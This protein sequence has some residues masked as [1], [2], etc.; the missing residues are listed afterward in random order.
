MMTNRLPLI[1][2]L[3]ALGL[4]LFFSWYLP[5]NH[6]F[7]FNI[8]STLFHFFN[9]EL[10]KSHTFLTLIAIT[11]NR[12]FDGISLLAMGVLFSWFWWHEDAPGRRR[13]VLMGVV[14][15]LA[16]VVINQ[17]GHL[18]PVVHS[19]PTLFFTD[20]N[21]VS[22]LLHF[23]TKDASSDSF[24]GDH[25]LMLLIFTGFMLRYFGLRAFLIAAAIFIIFSAPRIM[26]GAH[27]FTDVYVGSLSIAL[28]G[29]PW[30]LLTPLSDRLISVLNRTIPGK[31]K[32]RD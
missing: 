12:A 27:W 4:A 3:N 17:L 13:L 30:V 16:A 11:N 14:M 19:S 10:V 32:A 8:D 20:I 25:G 21:R 7:W 5:E 31:Y 15:L 22:E 29:L 28:V 2:L 26:I 1:L 9:N 6:G 18:I 24:P 23:P